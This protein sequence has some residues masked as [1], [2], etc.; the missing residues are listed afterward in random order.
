M[1]TL[2]PSMVKSIVHSDVDQSHCPDCINAAFMCC[3]KKQ[4][5]PVV[6]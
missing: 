5:F 1:A 4:F 2:K 3:G 6:K